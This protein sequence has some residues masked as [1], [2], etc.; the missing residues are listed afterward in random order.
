MALHD[1]G[2]RNCLLCNETAMSCSA[3]HPQELWSLE[4]SVDSEAALPAE[5][6][7]FVSEPADYGWVPTLLPHQTLHA[8]PEPLLSGWRHYKAKSRLPVL[9]PCSSA[10]GE[11]AMIAAETGCGKTPM[12]NPKRSW[13][14]E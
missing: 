12:T 8:S 2:N 3:D 4:G 5:N 7:T 1:F 6:L 14:R 11:D 9:L 10:R 13:C